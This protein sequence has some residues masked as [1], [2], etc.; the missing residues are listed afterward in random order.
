MAKEWKTNLSPKKYIQRKA[1]T[2]KL[3]KC[4]VNSN[5]KETGMANVVVTRRHTDGHYTYG[6]FLVDT[7]VMGTKDCFCNIHHSKYNFQ[8]FLEKMR[9]GSD[10]DV[11]TEEISYVLAHNII[12]GANAFAED[13]GFSPHPDFEYSQYILHED[14]EDIPL[15]E[16][17]FGLNRD[18]ISGNEI[19][20]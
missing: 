3:G 14:T 7:W 10:E 8:D 17:E 16:L 6:V 18:N 2:L 4:Y 5:W 1:R 12:Y 9:G 19:T 11:E 15:V 20:E 13:F